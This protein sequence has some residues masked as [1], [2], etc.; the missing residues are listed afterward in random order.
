MPQRI[1]GG[2]PRASHNQVMG[3]SGMHDGDPIAGRA[4]DAVMA[5]AHSVSIDAG[6]EP[7]ERAL[8]SAVTDLRTIE[9]Q[10]LLLGW[11]LRISG[12]L[13]SSIA[14]STAAGLALHLAGLA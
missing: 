7:L 11:L 3:G 14:G 10:E 2:S 6:L 5:I 12:D 4:V 9:H 1:D 8:S 13:A